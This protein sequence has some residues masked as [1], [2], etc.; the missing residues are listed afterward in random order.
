MVAPPCCFE[1]PCPSGRASLFMSLCRYIYELTI[2][3]GIEGLMASE[4]ATT[5][6]PIEVPMDAVI[7]VPSEAVIEVPSEAVIEVNLPKDDAKQVVA[8]DM[9]VGGRGVAQTL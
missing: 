7:E 6:Q 9:P 8:I 3:S 5:A 1:A 4:V 2:E